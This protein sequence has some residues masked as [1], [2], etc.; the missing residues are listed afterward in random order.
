MNQKTSAESFEGH[1]VDLQGGRPVCQQTLA[2]SF[3]LTGVGLHGGR[4]ARLRADPAPPNTG[5]CVAVGASWPRRAVAA[6]V[7]ETALGTCLGGPPFRVRTVEHCLAAFAGMGVD[8]AILTLLEGDEMPA[9][10]GSAAPVVV[11]ILAVGRRA[12]PVPGRRYVVCRPVTVQRADG[13][14][15]RLEPAMSAAVL[16]QYGFR[17]PVGATAFAVDLTPST[18][19]TDLAPAR[20][21][22]FAEDIEALK[23]A[24]WAQGGHLANAVVFG[25]DGPVNPEGLRY[26]DECARHKLLDAVGDLALLGLPW[27]GRYVGHRSGHALNVALVLRALRTPGVLRVET[28]LSAESCA[29]DDG[30]RPP[31]TSGRRI[32]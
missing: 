16:G 10:D 24:G 6:A 31:A 11:Q 30:V 26:V 9:L 32:D 7:T 8:N 13:A 23:A 14:F 18:F 29:A 12:Q 3:E 1:G 22:A 2:A 21:F 20:T 27:R 4:P 19:A 25:P 28:V 15:A 5:L 17:A